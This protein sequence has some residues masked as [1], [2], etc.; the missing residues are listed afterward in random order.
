MM[1]DVPF[2]V[3]R[4]PESIFIQPVTFQLHLLALPGWKMQFLAR[5][6]N[7]YWKK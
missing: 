4:K 1:L 7:G 2:S 6:E 5:K 3:Y